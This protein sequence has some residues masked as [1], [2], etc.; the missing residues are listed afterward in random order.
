MAYQQH[1]KVPLMEF[2]GRDEGRNIPQRGALTHPP[3]F[4]GRKSYSLMALFLSLG[5]CSAIGQ[6]EWY[7][8]LDGRAVSDVALSQS[9]AIR[10]GTLL[11]FLFKSCIVAAVAISFCQGFWYFVRRNPIPVDG[12]DAVV[13]VLSNPF[14]F[15]NMSLLLQTPYLMLLA[16]TCWTLPLTAV[17]SPGSL[18][19]LTPT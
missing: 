6:H 1:V 16:I 14:N 15:F 3:R 18:T 12:L 13:G 19:G 9:W 11:A 10:I 7:H 8:Y 2:G 4:P 17:L 5:L